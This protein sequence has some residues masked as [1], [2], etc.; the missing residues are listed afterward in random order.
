MLQK[1]QSC[2]PSDET[3]YMNAYQIHAPNNF[4]YHINIVVV[5]INHQLNIQEWMHLKYSMKK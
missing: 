1:I 2:Q 4:A 3:A 5:T